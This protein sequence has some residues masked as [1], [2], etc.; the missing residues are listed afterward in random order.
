MRLKATLFSSPAGARHWRGS[1][2]HST[3]LGTRYCR[4]SPPQSSR[5]GGRRNRAWRRSSSHRRP[6]SIDHAAKL[7]IAEHP[8]V[9]VLINNAGIM[10][11]D[12]AAEKIDEA[13]L[14]ATVQH[15]L[16]G[17]IA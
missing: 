12:Q 14:L 2:K 9:N 8:D 6:A 13:L 11:P 17:S 16:I 15:N 7:L 3:G 4:G 1:P 10:Q 5:R